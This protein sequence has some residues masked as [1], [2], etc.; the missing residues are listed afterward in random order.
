MY[1][2]PKSYVL[3]LTQGRNCLY[4]EG[5]FMTQN[6]ILE[7]ACIF[8]QLQRQNHE[9][10]ELGSYFKGIRDTMN[11]CYFKRKDKN[12]INDLISMEKVLEDI[13]K[14]CFD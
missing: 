11:Y 13:Y 7:T 2:N 10:E 14:R 6:Q 3:G 8:E 12:L 9:N 4:S 5:G 1:S